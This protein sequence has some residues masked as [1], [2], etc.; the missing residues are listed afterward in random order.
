MV[1]ELGLGVGEGGEVGLGL[2]PRSARA[3]AS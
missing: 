1:V 2:G 3:A